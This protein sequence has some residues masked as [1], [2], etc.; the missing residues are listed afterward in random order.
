MKEA[1]RELLII[2]LIDIEIKK[3]IKICKAILP[4]CFRV[5]HCNFVISLVT[6]CVFSYVCK[7][8]VKYNPVRD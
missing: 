1:E 3:F 6:N 8:G 2:L 4:R 5:A 7:F